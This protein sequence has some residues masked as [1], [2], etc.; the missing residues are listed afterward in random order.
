MTLSRGHQFEPHLSRSRGGAADATFRIVARDD[1]G[2]EHEPATRVHGAELERRRRDESVEGVLPTLHG[3]CARR[4]GD[5]AQGVDESGGVLLRRALA[6]G[7]VQ[8]GLGE[9]LTDEEER[10]AHG[11]VVTGE[12]TDG[13]CV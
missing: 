12:R 9:T 4:S 2:V 11:V 1:G 8:R 6:A 7:I 13:E 10:R 3:H 5:G